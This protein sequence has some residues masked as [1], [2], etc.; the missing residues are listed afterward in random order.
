MKVVQL[1][2][3]VRAALDRVSKKDRKVCH[4]L[5]IEAIEDFDYEMVN[6]CM[7]TYSQ[8]INSLRGAI[9]TL[10]VVL[11]CYDKGANPEHFAMMSRM[12]LADIDRKIGNVLNS[13]SFGTF[14]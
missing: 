12:D 10:D 5:L 1:S 8:L 9:K 4:D 14:N 3:S 6:S 13:R 7:P 11:K 2:S